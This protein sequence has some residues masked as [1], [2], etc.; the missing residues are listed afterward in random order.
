MIKSLFCLPSTHPIKITNA[1][2]HCY[3][4]LALLLV[5]FHVPVGL[6]NVFQGE[7]E[8]DDRFQ[9]TGCEPVVNELLATGKP[10]R[11]LHDLKQGIPPH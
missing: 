11:I 2:L 8:I 6:N 9:R 3:H 7:R 5:G 1:S 10:L 4:D